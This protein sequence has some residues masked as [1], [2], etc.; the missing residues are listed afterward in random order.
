MVKTLNDALRT[1]FI[2]FGNKNCCLRIFAHS[3]FEPKLVKL[4]YE[5]FHWINVT[6]ISFFFNIHNLNKAKHFDLCNNFQNGS[7]TQLLHFTTK[8]NIANWKLFLGLLRHKNYFVMCKN[9]WIWHSSLGFSSSIFSHLSVTITWL[10]KRQKNLAASFNNSVGFFRSP[11][12]RRTT[13]FSGVM[14]FSVWFWHV[15]LSWSSKYLS[16]AIDRSAAIT[17]NLS[18]CTRPV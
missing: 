7:A 17:S 2:L 10:G 16:A 15:N 13:Q 8:H 18:T 11:L 9:L 14:W 12:T 5:I 1:W 6:S 4:H 3:R